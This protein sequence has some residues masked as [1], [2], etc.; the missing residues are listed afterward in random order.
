VKTK[1]ARRGFFPAG[2]FLVCVFLP[3]YRRAAGLLVAILGSHE[4]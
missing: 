4:Q 2:G 1:N 3:D